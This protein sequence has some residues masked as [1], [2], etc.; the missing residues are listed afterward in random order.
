MA[1]PTWLTRARADIGVKEAPGVAD[2]AV[3]IGWAKAIGGWVASFYNHDSITWCALCMAHWMHD[4]G[5]RI[6][7]AGDVLAALK[8]RAWGVKLP[9]AIVGAVLIFQR[10]GGGHIGLY[11]G[12]DD[13]HFHV[14]GGNQGDKV[15][16]ERIPKFSCVDVR[17]P[18]EVE[19]FGSPLILSANGTPTN[20]SQA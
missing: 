15:C 6:P 16:I 17:W 11:V 5:K 19:P 20:T 10:T 18:E 9:K 13:T 14:L 12:E 8:W 2:N 1:E 3:I 7:P 4:D